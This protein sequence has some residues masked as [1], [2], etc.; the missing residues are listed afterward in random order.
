MSRLIAV[1]TVLL[2]VLVSGARAG[3]WSG[4]WGSAGPLREAAAR[5][6]HVPLAAGE[7]WDCHPAELGE[8]E[9]AVAE[10][11]GHLCRRYVHRHTGAPP[12]S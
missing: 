8:R 2:A 6:G 1:G 5:L 3:F 9:V 11:E 12:G 10:L 4:R 7:T